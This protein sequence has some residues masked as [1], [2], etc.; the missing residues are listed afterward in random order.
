MAFLFSTRCD[1][2]PAPGV[3]D[4]RIGD[5]SMLTEA[6]LPTHTYSI[7]ALDWSLSKST[8]AFRWERERCW[9]RKG[10]ERIVMEKRITRGS[11]GRQKRQVRMLERKFKEQGDSKTQAHDRAAQKGKRLRSRAIQSGRFISKSDERRELASR[12]KRKQGI[13]VR[14]GTVKLPNRITTKRE[15]RISSG[16]P[17]R[18]GNSKSRR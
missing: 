10:N 2:S 18:K 7:P 4:A 12:P 3:F 1:R 8:F 16:G 14:G 5:G 15:E 17:G 13:R 6:Q 11:S 9:K